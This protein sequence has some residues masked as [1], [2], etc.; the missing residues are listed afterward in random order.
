MW[1][2]LLITSKI[3]G[4]VSTTMHHIAKK[5]NIAEKGKEGRSVALVYVRGQNLN[6]HPIQEG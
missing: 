5:L 1:H 6:K 4:S 2:A 3:P